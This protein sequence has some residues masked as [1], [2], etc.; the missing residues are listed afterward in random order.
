[1]NDSN[2]T[3][4]IDRVS[5][6]RWIPF[7]DASE[8]DRAVVVTAVICAVVFVILIALGVV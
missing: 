4:R 5:K 6:D 1:M 8:G 7:E 3:G 2:W